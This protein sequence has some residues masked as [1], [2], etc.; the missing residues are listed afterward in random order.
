M[1]LECGD[2]ELANEAFSKAQIIEPEHA[3]AWLGQALVAYK[4]GDHGDAEAL[5]EHA[6]T[7]SSGNLVS[8][9]LIA[10]LSDFTHFLFS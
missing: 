3:S 2:A 5:F 4:K 7:L 9:I 6:S 1:C 8:V 10:F